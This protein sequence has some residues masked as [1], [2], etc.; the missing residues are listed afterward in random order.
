MNKSIE[1]LIKDI[2]LCLNSYENNLIQAYNEYRHN[3]A[4]SI[5]L[6]TGAI[7]CYDGMVKIYEESS[8]ENLKWIGKILND[9]KAIDSDVWKKTEPQVSQTIRMLRDKWNKYK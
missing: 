1:E 3:K 7:N 5:N 8:Y 2:N 6:P 9:I 4:L